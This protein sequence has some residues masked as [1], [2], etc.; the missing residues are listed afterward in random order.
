MKIYE[1]DEGLRCLFEG[2]NNAMGYVDDVIIKRINELVFNKEQKLLSLAKYIKEMKADAAAM[3]EAEQDIAKRRKSIEKRID[4]ASSYL[5][6]N[7]DNKISDSYI[8]VSKRKSEALIIE[9]DDKFASYENHEFFDEDIQWVIDKNKVKA[10]MK[11][12]QVFEGVRLEERYSLQI[13]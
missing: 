13:K 9:D 6:E 1:I 3:K 10:A 8:A 12:G 4:S 11:Q 7:L 5:L 2:V